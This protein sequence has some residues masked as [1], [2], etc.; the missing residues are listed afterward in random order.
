MRLCCRNSVPLTI[1]AKTCIWYY[2]YI[3]KYQLVYLLKSHWRLWKFLWSFSSWERRSAA[4]P[5]GQILPQPSSLWIFVCKCFVFLQVTLHTGLPIP[6]FYTPGEAD[7]TSSV[8]WRPQWNLCRVCPFPAPS[9]V[10]TSNPALALLISTLRLS[11]R[12]NDPQNT[13]SEASWQP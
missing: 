4:P 8:C 9:Q 3:S 6:D 11:P 13:P 2:M 1:T 10:N 12:P 5:A 7:P